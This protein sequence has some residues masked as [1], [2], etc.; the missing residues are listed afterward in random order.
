METHRGQV[1]RP[2]VSETWHYQDAVHHEANP[3]Y[4]REWIPYRVTE[5]LQFLLISGQS[6][7]R[8]RIARVPTSRARVQSESF[9]PFHG[10]CDRGMGLTASGKHSAAFCSRAY[11]AMFDL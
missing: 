10:G 11:E 7:R 1:G 6:M 5:P 3:L 8:V 2:V 9:S 4:R